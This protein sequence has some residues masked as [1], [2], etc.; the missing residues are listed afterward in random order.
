MVCACAAEWSDIPVP[1]AGREQCKWRV[2]GCE[3][4]MYWF[5]VHSCTAD[6]IKVVRAMTRACGG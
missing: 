2:E 1:A 5:K 4:L 6:P 3:V